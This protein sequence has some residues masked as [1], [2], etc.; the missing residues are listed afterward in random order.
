MKRARFAPSLR[1]ASLLR[2][3][4][5]ALAF[6]GVLAVP[7]AALAVGN[8]SVQNLAPEERDGRWKLVMTIKLPAPPPIAHVPVILTFDHKVEYERE[9]N[10]KSPDKPVVVRK[11]LQN[12]TPIN[13]G[14]DI[15]FSDASGKTFATTK[16]DF[17]LR[18]DRGFEAGEYTLTIKR[19][20]DG[21]T[22]GQPINLRLLGDNPVVDRRA[23]VFGTGKE[24]DTKKVKADPMST[25]EKDKDADKKDADADKKPEGEAAEPAAAEKPAEEAA[26]PPPVPPKQGGCGCRVAGEPAPDGEAAFLAVCAIALAAARRRW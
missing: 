10:D 11:P 4:A 7:R 5:I 15:G 21:A 22:L 14:M 23:M 8:V 6:F 1:F 24:S 3:V 16:F 19:E 18:R 9:L 20:S 26:A 25:G 2:F 12:Q 17:S 13:E